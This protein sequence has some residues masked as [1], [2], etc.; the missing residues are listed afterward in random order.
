MTQCCSA[1]SGFF[2]VVGRDAR[3]IC[4]IPGSSC[5]DHPT[6]KADGSTTLAL[7]MLEDTVYDN[8]IGSVRGATRGGM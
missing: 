2:A 1:R 7:G 3:T 6:Q 4:G 5:I 8:R